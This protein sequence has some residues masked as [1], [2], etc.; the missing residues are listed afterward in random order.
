V[1]AIKTVVDEILVDTGTTLQA[2]VDAIQ[3]KTDQLTFGT[4]NRV[5]AQVY[6]MEANVVTAAASA[7]D[8]VTEVQSGLSTLTEALVQSNVI[9]ALDEILPDSVPA[10]GTRPTVRQALYIITQFLTEK[11]V[12][13]T[14]VTV[15]KV[16]GTTSLLTLTLDDATNPTSITRA[17]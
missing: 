1:A 14:T 4:A 3:A 16:D 2:E 8:F 17:T 11:A 15:K 9:D 6:G 10:D 7:A 5:N 12:S 13:G